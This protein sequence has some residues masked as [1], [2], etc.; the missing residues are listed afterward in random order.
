M[1]TDVAATIR[2]KI[3]AGVLPH[4]PDSPEKC[5]VGKGTSRT[6]DGCDGVITAEQVEYYELDMSDGRTL[7]FHDKCLDTRHRAGAERMSE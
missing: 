2:D 3:R 4:P 5:F 6:C 7:R 1:A